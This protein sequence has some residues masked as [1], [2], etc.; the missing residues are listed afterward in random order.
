M[1]TNK[2]RTSA[3][4]NLF[5][6]MYTDQTLLAPLGQ[7]PQSTSSSPSSSSQSEKKLEE[8]VDR[9]YYSSRGDKGEVP[10]NDKDFY[11]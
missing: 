10:D 2:V 3:T 8:N 1:E 7:P 5:S 9:K 6:Q 4:I 11:L